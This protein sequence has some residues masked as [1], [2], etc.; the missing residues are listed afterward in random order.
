MDKVVAYLAFASTFAMAQLILPAAAQF[1]WPP[2]APTPKAPATAKS[3]S[4]PVASGPVIVGVWTG[5][6]TQVGGQ[7]PYKVQVTITAKGGETKYPDLNCE[8]KLS[9]IGAS[10]SYVFYIEVISTGGI[11]KGGRCPDGTIT[12]GKSGKGLAL[13]WFGSP[14]GNLIVAYG[15]LSKM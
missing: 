15:T 4:A 11:S 9:K 3:K 6:L 8:G 5:Q 13:G 10:K 12:A 1:P 14:D 7:S 2:D